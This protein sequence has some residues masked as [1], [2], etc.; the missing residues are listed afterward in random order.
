MQLE[1]KELLEILNREMPNWRE[2]DSLSQSEWVDRSITSFRD[3]IGRP[4]W[5]KYDV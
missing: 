5:T 3:F 2:V 1:T 4:V